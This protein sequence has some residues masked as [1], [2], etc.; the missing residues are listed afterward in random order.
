MSAASQAKSEKYSFEAPDKYSDVVTDM[1][2][3]NSTAPISDSNGYPESVRT[4]T[5]Y[6]LDHPDYTDGKFNHIINH[7]HSIPEALAAMSQLTNVD[8]AKLVSVSAEG[9]MDFLK[10][11]VQLQAM[12]VTSFPVSERGKAVQK[13][14]HSRM[15]YLL[16]LD[17]A[18]CKIGKGFVDRTAG[19]YHVTAGSGKRPLQRYTSGALRA[20]AQ[21]LYDSTGGTVDPEM[22]VLM[23][24]QFKD[25]SVP[26]SLF[27]NTLW[28]F[29]ELVVTA[30][31]CPLGITTMPGGGDSY[32]DVNSFSLQDS[33]AQRSRGE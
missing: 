20:S 31:V 7:L 27:I 29:F 17:A 21:R 11:M 28:Q 16:Q 23:V 24:C 22:S 1:R 3:D 8:L 2:F 12:A 10:R 33:D 13:Y 18:M 4:L 26:N 19:Q 14:G 30:V 5:E 6:L 9:D 15:I 32:G 25:V